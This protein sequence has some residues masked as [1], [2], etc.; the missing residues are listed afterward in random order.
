[1]EMGTAILP[2]VSFL[3][4]T[5]GAGDSRVGRVGIGHFCDECALRREMKAPSDPPDVPAWIRCTQGVT[6]LLK[7]LVPGLSSAVYSV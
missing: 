6:C 7:L 5:I 2:S 4:A 1:M 3:M